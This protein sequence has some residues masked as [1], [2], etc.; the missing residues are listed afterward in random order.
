MGYINTI[1][2]LTIRVYLRSFSRCWLPNL[3]NPATFQEN[4]RL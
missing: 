2:S 1:P 3:R 4:S